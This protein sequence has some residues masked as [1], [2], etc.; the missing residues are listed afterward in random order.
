MTSLCPPLNWI[1]PLLPPSLQIFHKE[2][3]HNTY[4]I[5]HTSSEDNGVGLRELTLL[6]WQVVF[7]CY[8][9]GVC[10]NLRLREGPTGE[11]RGK[12]NGVSWGMSHPS[13]PSG[14]PSNMNRHRHKHTESEDGSKSG[15]TISNQDG[16][17]PDVCGLQSENEALKRE[18]YHLQQ[19]QICLR[20]ENKLLRQTVTSQSSL[21][22]LHLYILLL[23][24]TCRV[25]C[26]QMTHMM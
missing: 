21:L 14:S 18:I 2:T 5:P 11:L 6:C 19:R 23:S 13:P 8:G 24:L 25:P 20:E 7:T 9:G 4:C 12:P 3:L 26:I 22:C 10:W 15:R 17:N 1:V 16:S